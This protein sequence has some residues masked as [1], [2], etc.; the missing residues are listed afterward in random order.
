[1]NHLLFL[2]CIQHWLF[3]SE[4]FSSSNLKF[5]LGC[6]ENNYSTFGF[7]WILSNY[8]YFSGVLKGFNLVCF[9]IIKKLLQ[10]SFKP[11]L[12]L[13]PFPFQIATEAQ[14]NAQRQHNF[15]VTV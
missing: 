13:L 5:V 14:Q 9:Y 3:F 8:D 6:K 1:V 7:I 15:L 11:Y 2:D 4:G 10:R 12:N